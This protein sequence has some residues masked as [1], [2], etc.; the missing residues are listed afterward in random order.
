MKAPDKIY[1]DPGFSGDFDLAT[2]DTEKKLESDVEYILK[3]TLL[4]WAQEHR[5]EFPEDE[6]ERG[7]NMAIGDIIEK[8]N[9]L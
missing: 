2:W 1:L 8:I 6:F 7:F 4:E 9:S 5:W 3:D